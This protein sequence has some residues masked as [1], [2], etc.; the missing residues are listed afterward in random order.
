[1][2][3]SIEGDWFPGEIPANAVIGDDVYLDS[4]Y[5]FAAFRS[6]RE[7]GLVLGE[8]SGIYNRAC[9]VVGAGGVV[10]VGD[11]TVLNGCYLIAE[12]RITIGSHCL[13]AWGVT[14]SDCWPGAR[15]PVSRR[16]QLL[17]EAAARPDRRLQAGLPPEPV[18]IED[19]VWVGFDSVILPGVTLGRGSIIA[20]KTIVDC[21]VPSYAVFAGNPGRV[22]RFL[23]PDDDEAAKQR[24][25]HEYLIDRGNGNIRTPAYER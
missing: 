18:T 6:Q 10:E 11:Y 1:M 7:P 3:R 25:M 4:S 13:L 22:L 20:C 5:S 8:A 15:L 19:N 2:G 23:D 24:A 14:I 9:L 16:R 17:E 21:N 12:N